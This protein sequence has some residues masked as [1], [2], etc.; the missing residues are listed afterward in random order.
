MSTAVFDAL[1]G[2]PRPL[3]HL[4]RL[5]LPRSDDFQITLWVL[6]ELGYR[7]IEGV[8]AEWECERSV[9][10]LRGQLEAAQEAELRDECAGFEAVD[11]PALSAWMEEHGTLEHMREFVAHRAPYQLKEADPHSFAIPRLAAGRAKSAL[12]KIQ[13][14]EYGNGEL[15]ESHQELFT[16][17]MDALG[18]ALDIDTIPAVTLR[19]NTVL[20]MFGGQRRLLPA[21]LGHLAVFETTSV[22]PMAR[23]AQTLRVLLPSDEGTRAARFYDVHVAADAFHGR[24][25]MDEMVAGFIEQYPE[26]AADVAFGGLAVTLVESELTRHLIACW[27]SGRSSLRTD[28]FAQAA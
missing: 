27:E 8:A 26:E 6:Q 25:A 18:V 10:E 12:L 15:G 11:G 4:G 28:S 16:E 17:T 20:N 7:P 3:P 24:I 5:P 13:L 19:T 1:R 21:L 14:D 22:E 9:V 23:Y 2:A